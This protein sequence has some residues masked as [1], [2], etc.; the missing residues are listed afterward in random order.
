MKPLQALLLMIAPM[1]LAQDAKF[2]VDS[3]LSRERIR[4]R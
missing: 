3:N 1:L 2:K 4:E